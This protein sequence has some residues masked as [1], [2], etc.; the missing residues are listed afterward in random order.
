[1]KKLFLVL[2]MVGLAFA[3]CEP[4]GNEPNNGGNGENNG[5]TE[6]VLGAAEFNIS[7]ENIGET[8]AV[9]KVSPKQEGRSF[10]WNVKPES[11]LKEFATTKAY[12]EDWFAY[13]GEAIASGN[14]QWSDLLDSTAV[15]F[16]HT[17]L[18]PGTK[19]V[20]WAFGIDANGNLTSADLSYV[21]FE[22]KA[23]TFDPTSWYGYWNVTAPKH[24]S[25]GEDPF[26]GASVTEF[27][28][29]ELEK[30]VAITDASEDFGAG[31]VYVW[32]WDGVF[33]TE[34]PALGLISGNKIKMANDTV[35][36]TEDDPDYG[37]LDYTWGGISFLEGYGDWYTIGGSY[38]CYTITNTGSGAATVTAYKGQLTDG[39]A[40]MTD[41]YTLKAVIT[42]GQYEGY[43][44]SFSRTDGQ[45]AL[46]LSGESMTAAFLAPLEEVAAQKLNANKKFKV[47]HKNATPRAAAKFSSA[48]NFVK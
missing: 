48:V 28:D 8:S 37:P 7:V 14:Y 12:M 43:S 17:N 20:L 46:Y 6:N 26:S 5:S 10:Y 34:L 25:I 21:V 35:L 13:L 47:A 9:L 39:S 22:T 36:F 31:Y 16:E 29:T 38:D 15:E 33:E 19:Y 41:Y 42:T 4:S 27:V 1:M 3:S 2:A 11:A 44:L 40:F 23:S 32:G 24:V 45:P 18:N 30:V